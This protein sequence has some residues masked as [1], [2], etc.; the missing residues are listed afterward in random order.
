MHS[1]RLMWVEDLSVIK[2]KQKKKIYIVNQ[3]VSTIVI[4]L[5]N[6]P[7]TKWTT[8]GGV[9]IYINAQHPQHNNK[10]QTTSS[11]NAD[12]LSI[13]NTK[14]YSDI[15]IIV[16]NKR[17]PC[18][19]NIISSRSSFFF[20][21]VQTV[22]ENEIELKDVSYSPFMVVLEYLYSDKLNVTSIDQAIEVW[23]IAEKYGLSHL[24]HLAE[25]YVN[26]KI[27][28][29]KAIEACQ[30]AAIQSLNIFKTVIAFLANN[31]EEAMELP[32]FVSIPRAMLH[33]VLK[34]VKQVKRIV[35][36]LDPDTT[37]TK[38]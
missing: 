18:H 1:R 19:R 20:N 11:F 27:T 36:I 15:S 16:E 7:Y 31:F 8:L 12:F 37:P 23:R 10:Q 29:E 30:N 22:K 6:K 5:D 9:D 28:C 25:V 33:D 35:S 2:R 4:M 21:L 3:C 32:S 13:L 24:K 14:L 38:P 26:E 34:R 17:I